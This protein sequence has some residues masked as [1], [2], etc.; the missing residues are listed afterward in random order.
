[1]DDVAK[2]TSRAI[3]TLCNSRP[4]KSHMNIRVICPI[5]I[6]SSVMY[7]N[8][9]VFVPQSVRADSVRLGHG[10]LRLC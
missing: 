9:C 1:M 6:R 2:T 4:L 3:R 7:T 8:S 10:T 5:T